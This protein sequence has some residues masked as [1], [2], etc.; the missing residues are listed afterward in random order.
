M[1]QKADR[2]IQAW[3]HAK[4]QVVADLLEFMEGFLAEYPGGVL[5][6]M[7]D[8]NTTVSCGVTSPGNVFVLVRRIEGD[9]LTTLVDV[10]QR[11]DD[12]ATVIKAFYTWIYEPSVDLLTPLALAQQVAPTLDKEALVAWIIQNVTR[13]E[14][15]EEEAGLVYNLVKLARGEPDRWDWG[16]DQRAELDRL[17]K[18]H[19]PADWL[20][21]EKREYLY[22]IRECFGPE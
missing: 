3:L 5:S 13:K 9:T 20:E 19:A 6:F 18:Q 2:R 4:K 14:A 1:E 10:D 11:R 15:E 12:V 22:L 17:R 8:A 7:P 16:D 21:D